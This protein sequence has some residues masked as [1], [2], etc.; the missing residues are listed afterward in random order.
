MY[1]YHTL[2]LVKLQIEKPWH[3]ENNSNA[4]NTNGN[5]DNCNKKYLFGKSEK[6]LIKIEI[7]WIE[8]SPNIELV[9]CFIGNRYASWLLIC[10]NPKKYDTFL[11][12]VNLRLQ[13]NVHIKFLKCKLWEI[14]YTWFDWKENETKLGCHIYS[15]NLLN[16][17]IYLI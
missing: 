14:K 1:R 9:N 16:L 5:N 7:G 8:V 4:N 10:Y 2:P 15:L 17:F 12:Y 13:Q 6:R 3:N 11:I